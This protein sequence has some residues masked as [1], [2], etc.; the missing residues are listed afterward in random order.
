GSK[1]EGFGQR[2]SASDMLT[3]RDWHW[4]W[5]ASRNSLKTS[6]DQDVPREAVADKIPNFV[7]RMC[8]ISG[9]DYTKKND[10]AD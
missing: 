5:S 10:T 1:V 2:A 3:D 7:H 4:L 8:W 6:T 9:R